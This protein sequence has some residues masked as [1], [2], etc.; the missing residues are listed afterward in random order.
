MHHGRM[1][2]MG[3]PN[4]VFG[5]PQTAELRQFPSSLQD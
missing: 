2:E 5:N 4:D 3:L 1:H